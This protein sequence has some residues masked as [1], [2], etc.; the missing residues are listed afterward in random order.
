VKALVTGAEGMLGADLCAVLT[1]AG[2]T[3]VPASRTTLDVT[4]LRAARRTVAEHRPDVVFHAA[5]DTDVDRAEQDPATADRVNVVGTWNVALACVETGAQLVYVSSGGVFDGLKAAPYIEL[6][7]PNPLTRYHRGKLAGERIVESHVREHFIL[8]P[9]W[10]FGGRAD[11]RKNFVAQRYREAR[12]AR[13][14]RSAADRFGSP[15]YTVDFARAALALVRTQAF[16]LYHV[17]NAGACSRFDYVSASVACCDL[18]TAVVPAGSDELPPR[19]A[20]VPAWEALENYFMALRGL[21]PM[22]PWREALTDYTATRLLP[23]LAGK[24]DAR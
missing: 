18:D 1:Q 6:D 19:R 2:H 13:Q 20:T 7:I 5:A 16:G 15:T 23:E 12:G 3:A 4:D 8:R 22:R 14:I 21:P 10:L 17:A 24:G 9:G 11:H